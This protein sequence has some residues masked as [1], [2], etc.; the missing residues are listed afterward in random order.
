M[1][2][3]VVLKGNRG[4]GRQ[5]D[6]LEHVLYA[7]ND[8]SVDALLCLF[9]KYGITFSIEDGKIAGVSK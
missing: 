8:I 7:S 4:R 3:Y 2:K 5:F 1:K 9:E 6:F